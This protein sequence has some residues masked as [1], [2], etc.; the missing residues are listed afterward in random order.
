M[1]PVK[2]R[3]HY[4]EAVVR[5]AREIPRVHSGT[6]V[7]CTRMRELPA[8]TLTHVKEL[9]RMEVHPRRHRARQ[10]ALRGLGG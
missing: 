5:V 8:R 3:L 10:S 9:L 6:T 4:R 2:L 7:A 1:A